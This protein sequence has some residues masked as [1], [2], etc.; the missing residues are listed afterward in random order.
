M[1][2]YH[3]QNARIYIAGYD[4][5]SLAVALTPVQEIEVKSYAVMDGIS[6]YHQLRGVAK[7]A[8][9]I[10]GLFD[11]NYTAVLT[12]LFAST[13]GYQIM[14]PFGV[15]DGNRGLAVDSAWLQR[16][17]FNA[18]VTDINKLTG[19]LVAENLPWDEVVMILSKAQKV[20]DGSGAAYNYGAAIT[21]IVGYLQV[22]TCGAGDN[23]IVKVQSDD[24]ASF[25]SP[26]D[27]ITFTTANGITTE[28]S[29]ANVG[30]DSYLKI[31]WAGTAPWDAT[32]AVGVKII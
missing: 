31:T 1:A 29:T 23:L 24:N 5:S 15:T 26:T 4:I 11:D 20:A 12:A 17:K 28:R 22:F 16:Y 19:E 32:F 18:V 13:T 30:V 2:I 21:S 27:R 10:D 9:S 14:I 25:T 6:G 8:L 7:D 3:G